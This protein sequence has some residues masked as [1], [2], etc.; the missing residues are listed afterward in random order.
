MFDGCLALAGADYSSPGASLCSD[1]P[2]PSENG[3]E[4]LS[5][6]FFL[7]DGAFVHK[8]ISGK[9]GLYFNPGFVFFFKTYLS[10]N[11]SLF[12]LE[13]PIMHMDVDW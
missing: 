9:P 6:R 10:G 7:G 4:S 5:D 1:V 3:V 2:L 13:H 8:L 11:F 12:F